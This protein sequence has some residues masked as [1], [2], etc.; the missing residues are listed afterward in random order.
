MDAQP[1]RLPPNLALWM[2]AIP[3]PQVILDEP[4]VQA[5]I[6]DRDPVDTMREIQSAAYKHGAQAVITELA[7]PK[8][9]LIL[10]SALNEDWQRF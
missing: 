3:A 10:I 6:K 1:Q 4:R 5:A 9:R 7:D 8:G 2:L